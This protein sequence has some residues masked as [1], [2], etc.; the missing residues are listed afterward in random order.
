MPLHHAF[1][2]HAQDVKIK[3]AMLNLAAVE[4][5]GGARSVVPRNQRRL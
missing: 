4:G 2:H 3:I 5:E 1:I